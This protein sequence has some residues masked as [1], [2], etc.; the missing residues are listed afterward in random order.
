VYRETILQSG[1]SGEQ[2][3]ELTLGTYNN[4]VDSA[5]FLKEPGVAGEY[6]QKMSYVLSGQV[7]PEVR[8]LQRLVAQ[9]GQVRR[10]FQAVAAQNL[11]LVT[12]RYQYLYRAY[13]GIRKE[14]DW[15]D[16][17]EIV[18]FLEIDN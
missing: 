8:L 5:S 12:S 3:I 2:Q 9:Y 15:Q 18:K 11:D 6:L 1:F 16:E 13:I 7:R 17:K 14:T 4:N 10:T